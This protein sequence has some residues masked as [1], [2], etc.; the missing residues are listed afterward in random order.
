[1]KFEI[2]VDDLDRAKTIL[3]EFAKE[4]E[5]E[6]AKQ[7]KETKEKIR[8]MIKY[9][10]TRTSITEDIIPDEV[11]FMVYEENGK[12]YINSSAYVPLGANWLLK[13]KMK[14]SIK[15][16]LEKNGIKVK[17][18]EIVKWYGIVCYSWRIGSRKNDVISIPFL[19]KL[20]L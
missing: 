2:E 19:V 13:R 6:Y 9:I 5:V 1:M 16:F 11:L 20:V 12:L 7:I 3:E 17:K 4:C 18:V 10:P 8:N 15:A 14:N